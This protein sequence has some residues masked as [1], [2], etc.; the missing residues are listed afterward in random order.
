VT[1][2][3]RRLGAVLAAIAALIIV[4]VLI[5]NPMVQGFIQDLFRSE[6]S[7]PEEATFSLER[8][9]LIDANG[10]EVTSFS[11]RTPMPHDIE[12]DGHP[13]QRISS[14]EG[15]PVWELEET[16]NAQWMVWEGDG[17]RGDDRVN[18][19]V[20]YNVTVSTYIWNIREESAAG[21]DQIPDELRDR[22][23][24]DEWKIEVSDPEIETTAENI[25]GDEENVYRI[26]RA[27]FDWMAENIEYPSVVQTGGPKGSVET[28]Q[29]GVGDCDDQAILFCSLARA[30]GVPAWLQLGVLYDRYTESWGGHGWVEAYVPLADGSAVNV[31]IDTANDDFMIW[32]PNRFVEYIDDGS[33]EHLEGYY[34]S[35]QLTYNPLSYPPGGG[36]LM[37]TTYNALE[38]SESKNRVTGDDFPVY[39]LSYGAV[40]SPSWLEDNPLIQ[41]VHDQ[42]V[43]TLPV[44]DVK[45]LGKIVC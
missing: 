28:L 21:I 39:A 31:T 37:E 42:P 7:Y 30:V 22:Y 5:L 23:L 27:I 40:A 11:V 43:Q 45:H 38:H 6:R 26:L 15:E 2:G 20:T 4:L 25:V 17:L 44:S 32:S 3:R 41:H 34:S 13:I 12:L 33:A 9:F 1:N 24:R 29:D 16:Q 8:K 14:V 36:P 18:I 35:M 19:T 10:G